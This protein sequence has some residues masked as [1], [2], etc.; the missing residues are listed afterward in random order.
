MKLSSFQ[1]KYHEGESWAGANPKRLLGKLD[2]LMQITKK[3]WQ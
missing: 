3:Y 1:K 2:R